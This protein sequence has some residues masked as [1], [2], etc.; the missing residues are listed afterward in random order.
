LI[1]IAVM[2]L[3]PDPRAVAAAARTPLTCIICGDRGGVDVVLNVLLFIPL[4]FGLRLAGWTRRRV[5]AASL[6]LSFTIESL[7]YFVIT[8]RDASLGDVVSNSTG[9]MIGAALV[10]VC[11][12]LLAPST[13]LAGRLLAAACLVWV[14]LL[15]VSAWL[16]APGAQTWHLTSR[17]A[18]HAPDLYPFFGEVTSVTLDGAEM[19]PHGPPPGRG[20]IAKRLKQGEAAVAIEAL[21]GTPTEDHHWLYMMKAGQI[22]QLTVTQKGRSA[23]LM[24]PARASRYKLRT[25]TLSLADGFPSQA[26]V[27]VSLN[28]GRHGDTVRVETSYAG[29]ERAIEITLSPAHGWAMIAPFNFPMGPALRLVTT[30]W[31]ALWTIPLGYWGAR[32]RRPAWAAGLIAVT[33]LVGLGVVPALGG[34]APVH[35]SEWLSAALSAA[36]GW[37]LLRPAAYLQLRCG[38]P[39]TNVSSSS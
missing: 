35:W 19:P 10:P 33:L 31:L 38:S 4:G 12:A 28:G 39:S 32:T 3:Q 29:E 34:H 15:A 18:H 20:E 13:R 7:Q 37:A 27:P 1:A 14:L 17:W 6:L 2:T 25:P 16:Q 30:L 21:S 11:F 36:A 5:A 24:V 22:P 8:G 26:G 23:V 9:G